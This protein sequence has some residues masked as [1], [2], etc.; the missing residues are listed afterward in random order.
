MYTGYTYGTAQK[1]LDTRIRSAG[2]ALEGDIS[3]TRYKHA[4]AHLDFS[5]VKQS[6]P[7]ILPVMSVVDLNA[8]TC[9]ILSSILCMSE[10]RREAN[11]IVQ[12]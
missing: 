9:Y 5:C 1:Q 11:V 6:L 8:R 12:W 2:L 10:Q 7:V 4:G 3:T